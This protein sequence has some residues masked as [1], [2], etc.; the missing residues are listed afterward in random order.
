VTPARL[1]A[2]VLAVMALAG[3]GA[4][5]RPPRTSPHVPVRQ[6]SADLPRLTI[7]Q[8]ARRAHRVAVVVSHGSRVVEGAPGTPFTRTTFA[9]R[10]V[11]KGALPHRFVLQTIGGRL[12]DV[13]V[14]SPVP[15]FT[16]SRAYVLFLGR[17]GP[18]GPTIFPQVVLRPRP[19]TVSAIRRA[20]R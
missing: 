11:L 4:A 19:G 10:R 9:V 7:A 8:A 14:T 5:A 13:V 16:R 18:A 15:G 1:V 3:C 2:A 20:L 17:D 6:T 12:G